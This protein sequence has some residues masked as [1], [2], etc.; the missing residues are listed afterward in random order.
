MPRRVAQLGEE[1]SEVHQA[2]GV[3]LRAALLLPRPP[4]DPLHHVHLGWRA[5]CT[6]VSVGK[7]QDTEN[8]HVPALPRL[9]KHVRTLNSPMTGQHS[10]NAEVGLVNPQN[11]PMNHAT[12]T[13]YGFQQFI[14]NTMGQIKKML[15]HSFNI[16]CKSQRDQK[17]RYPCG[18][19]VKHV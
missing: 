16:K 3:V 8:Q 12:S 11:N 1:P 6:S 15:P 13:P 17:P 14:Y 19:P 7:C 4:H 18:L 10:S 9:S 5:K 2:Q